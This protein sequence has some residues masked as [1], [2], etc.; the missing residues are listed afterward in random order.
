MQKSSGVITRSET[1]DIV[2]SQIEAMD[3]HNTVEGDI[4]RGTVVGIVQERT[5]MKVVY[6][7]CIS[8]SVCVT[9]NITSQVT[10]NVKTTVNVF[11]DG[12]Y[13]N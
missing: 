9:C 3:I 13:D 6:R 2:V 10:N 1:E 7:I 5:S 4:P 11:D 12:T 8:R